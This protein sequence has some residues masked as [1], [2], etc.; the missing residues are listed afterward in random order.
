MYP[1]PRVEFE[2]E[3]ENLRRSQIENELM[4]PGNRRP[5]LKEASELYRQAPPPGRLSSLNKNLIPSGLEY[6][7]FPA[8]GTSSSSRASGIKSAPRS[9]RARSRSPS[10]SQVPYTPPWEAK[11]KPTRES[12][13]KKLIVESKKDVES[14]IEAIIEKYGAGLTKTNLAATLFEIEAKKIE[15]NGPETDEEGKVV[16]QTAVSNLNKLPRDQI[17]TRI[18]KEINENPAYKKIYIRHLD[19]QLKK[20]SGYIP[21]QENCEAYLEQNMKHLVNAKDLGLE[22]PLYVS[23]KKINAA[24]TA[25]RKRKTVSSSPGEIIDE[26]WLGKIS[27]GY[28]PTTRGFQLQ[29]VSPFFETPGKSIIQEEKL[30]LTIRLTRNITFNNVSQ[31]CEVEFIGEVLNAP[32]YQG[33]KQARYDMEVKLKLDNLLQGIQEIQQLRSEL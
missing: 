23:V 7:L 22:F 26:Q 15:D 10:P 3:L 24:S 9:S 33:P 2:A 19:E 27:S 32:G 11:K 13:V 18:I 29:L 25:T 17:E 6:L 31:K 1:R 21:D 5:E 8:P 4:L 14:P 28:E 30:P 16:K 20:K 12:K